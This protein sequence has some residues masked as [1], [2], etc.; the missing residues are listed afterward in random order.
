MSLNHWWSLLQ[1]L[2]D[3]DKLI[4]L[5]GGSLNRRLSTRHSR[6][7]LASSFDIYTPRTSSSYTPYLLLLL[8]RSAHIV[9]KHTHYVTRLSSHPVGDY[10][11]RPHDANRASSQ[12]ASQPGVTRVQLLYMANKSAHVN[13]HHVTRRLTTLTTT[14]S[15][16]C[17]C[18]SR[19]NLSPLI[20]SAQADSLT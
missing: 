13:I 19:M 16:H 9:H 5:S 15:N 20:T 8:G 1:S 4:I 12:S 3:G 2:D 10:N 7:S 11:T 14:T 17:M 18:T 6:W